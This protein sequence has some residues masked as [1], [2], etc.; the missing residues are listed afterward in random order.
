M[1][2]HKKLKKEHK[3]WSKE[4]I[5]AEAKRILDKYAEDNKDRLEKEA[6]KNK[7]DFEKALDREFLNFLMDYDD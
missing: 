7:E 5:D 2:L 4:Q 1:S 6:K 3:D